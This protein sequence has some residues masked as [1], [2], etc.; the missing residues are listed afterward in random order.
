MFIA[1]SGAT[2]A[3]NTSTMLVL[4]HGSAVRLETASSNRYCLVTTL[5]ILVNH[6]SERLEPVRHN[7]VKYTVNVRVCLSK[8][9]RTNDDGADTATTAVSA[10]QLCYSV[11][12]VQP[13]ILLRLFS[14]FLLPTIT[15]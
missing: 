9:S 12:T 13:D 3:V 1:G 11:P 5:R 6:R 14:R 10:S 7:R 15:E 8:V 2:E 4:A